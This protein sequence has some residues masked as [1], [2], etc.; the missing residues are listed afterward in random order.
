MKR[1][2]KITSLIITLLLL[3]GCN[4]ISS[5]AY[6]VQ[7]SNVSYTYND[8][9]TLIELIAEQDSRM[10]AANQMAEAAKHLGHAEVVKLAIAEYQT[11]NE[12]KE[13]Y[14]AIYDDLEEHWHQ[15]EE[16]YPVATY[17]WSYLKGL[18]YNDQVCAGI[19]GNMMREVGGDT[20]NLQY[21]AQNP[22]HYGIC[23][24]SSKY[25]PDVWDAS[26]EV[27][28]DY[29]RD[30]IKKEFNTFG[31]NYKK[32]FSYEKFIDLTDVKKAAAAFAL[33]YERCGS[34]NY[35]QRVNNAIDAYRYFIS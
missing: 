22:T 5:S 25:Y 23:Q 9:D 26:L 18:G 34:G 30:T 32:G 27:Q 8:L 2:K 3:C 12:Q 31:S 15:K 20:L 4:G 17:I 7:Y 28:C 19:L 11:A 16:E 1:I 24:W 6:S 14:Q 13:K 29:L 10:N 33:C 35:Q 21:T